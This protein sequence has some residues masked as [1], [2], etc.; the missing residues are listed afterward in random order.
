MRKFVSALVIMITISSMGLSLTLAADE[1]T[2]TLPVKEYVDK[3]KGGWIGQMAGVGWGAP[4]EFRYCSSMIPEARV[5]QWKSEMVNQF[6]QDDIYVEMTFLRTL[7]LYGLDVSIRQAGIDFANSGY[8]LWHANGQGRENLRKGIAPPDSGHPR[9]NRHADDIDYQIEADF[10]GLI[11]PGAPNIVIEL[12]EKFGR[13]MNYGDGL[14]GGFFV[15][16]MYAE[17]FF[18]ED[19]EK[20]VRAGLACLPRGSQYH[21]CISDVLKWY[22]QN[23]DDWQKTWKL[24]NDKYQ[25]DPCYRRFS[26]EKGKFN[27]DAKINGAYIAIGLLYGKGDPDKT[28]IISMRCGQDSDCNPSSAAGIICANIGFSGLPERFKSAL[29]PEGKFSHTAYNFPT[30]ISVC[31]KLAREVVIRNGGRI[32]KDSSGEEVFVIPSVEPKVPA[33][34]QCWTAG[35]IANSLFTAE[36][37]AKIKEA[38]AKNEVSNDSGDNLVTI[39]AGE[40]LMG[41][42]VLLMVEGVKSGYSDERPAH[43]LYIDQ[44]RIG[45]YEVTNM[46]F[47]EFLNWAKS[48]NSPEIQVVDNVVYKSGSTSYAYCETQLSNSL[49]RICFN[50]STFT[51]TAGRGNHPMIL[52][53]WYGA[54]AYCNWRSRVHGLEQVYDLGTWTADFKKRG[55]HLPTEAQWERAAR[56]GLSG[57][58]FPWGDNI[59]QAQVNYYSTSSHPFDVSVSKHRHHPVWG[60]GAMPYTSAVGFFDGSLRQK[61][62]YDWPGD[63]ESYQTANGAND[64][65]LYDMIGN[66]WEWCND[67]YSSSYYSLSPSKNPT[68]PVS[69]TGR[70][71]RGGN[72]GHDTFGC[73]VANRYKL[74]P[75]GRMNSGVGFRVV[76]DVEN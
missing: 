35:A 30:L 27:I 1:K 46:Q 54:A 15:G 26:C 3:M 41:D 58:R 11:S 22:E 50:G 16:G 65:G 39:P 53:S 70:V 76:L 60:V 38:T 61:S 64:F 9:F 42:F 29:D 37:M 23:P 14:Y 21:E 12:G 28:T 7:E 55:F 20:I 73:R 36:E 62:D 56:G 74:S 2:R 49:S 33:L 66:A 68:G 32:E 69:G 52:V 6:N 34:E 59:S 48:Q 45:K 4:T 19:A 75:G 24:L 44:F 18:E 57:K 71:V 5:P 47:C 43:K 8:P 25:D 40:F 51:V 10:A 63:F 67:W 13:L 31:E 17:A 72:W